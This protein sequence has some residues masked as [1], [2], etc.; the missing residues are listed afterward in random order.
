MA[1]VTVGVVICGLFYLVMLSPLQG[2]SAKQS[3]ALATLNAEINTLQNSSD[4]AGVAAL[5]EM[6]SHDLTLDTLLPAEIDTAQEFTSL[7]AQMTASGLTIDSFASVSSTG[8]TGTVTPST[9]AGADQNQ[10][11][12]QVT[13]TPSDVVT[14]LKALY[15]SP[16][17]TT[18]ANMKLVTGNAILAGAQAVT[19]GVAV[20]TGTII[21]W[22]ALT[23]GITAS[24]TTPST[25]STTGGVTT[26]TTPA[27]K[28][29]TSP[30]TSRGSTA[31]TTT[32]ANTSVTTSTV[33]PG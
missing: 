22:N 27:T 30:D 17:M 25:T 6:Y 15:A 13:G 33:A 14:W 23:P 7:P 5:Q 32:P 18:T 9:V 1:I 12:F 20:V 2:S 31:T 21:V 29:V 26:V 11:S 16:V 8:T 28:R 24:T 3:S 4:T 10:F 19:A